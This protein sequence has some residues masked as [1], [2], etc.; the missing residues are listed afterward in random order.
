MVQF[1]GVCAL[2]L[3]ALGFVQHERTQKRRRLEQGFAAREKLGGS[4]F[5]ERYFARQGIPSDVVA[6]VRDV[7]ESALG[8]DLSSLKD[9]DD[10]SRNLSF[11]WE[12][13][14]MADVEIVMALEQRFGIRIADSEAQR[15]TTIRQ[16]VELVHAKTSARGVP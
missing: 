15:T 5:H 6:G 4:M 11:F 1:L 10:L 13:D 3:L 7:L 2:A 8:A 12:F 16:L 9:S 14:S